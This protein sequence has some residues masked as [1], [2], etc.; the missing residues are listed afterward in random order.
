MA[1]SR[2]RRRHPLGGRQRRGRDQPQPRRAARSAGA[3]ARRRV[4]RREARD[5]L[6]GEPRRRSG[7]CRGQRVRLICAEPAFNPNALCVV[8]TDRNEARATY[9]NFAV[10]PSQNV[11]AAPGGAGALFCADDVISTVPSGTESVCGTSTPGYDFYAGTSMATPHVAGVA[12]LLT[13]QGRNVVEVYSV[14][15]STARTPGVATRDVHADVRIRHR[16]CG[17]GCRGAL[18][19]RSSRS[20]RPPSARRFP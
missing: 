18:R 5:R 16:R 2:G 10:G 17:G 7:G 13:A 1:A 4:R 12:A 8:A 20:R 3:P 11:I 19:L 6:R 14:L 15:K 9:S